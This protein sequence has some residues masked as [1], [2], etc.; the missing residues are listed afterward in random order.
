[1]TS[2]GHCKNERAFIVWKTVCTTM[3]R[4]LHT[5]IAVEKCKICASNGDNEQQLS[6]ADSEHYPFRDCILGT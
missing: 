4:R 2:P 1:M 6:V 3:M 5:V